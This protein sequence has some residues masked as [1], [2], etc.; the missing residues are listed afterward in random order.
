M[1]ELYSKKDKISLSN[2]MIQMLLIIW[3]DPKDLCHNYSHFVSTARALN[4]R[5]LTIHQHPICP[6]Y[7]LTRKGKR[8]V[9]KILREA[10]S[11]NIQ[12]STQFP[13]FKY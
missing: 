7:L 3:K 1:T 6:P 11:A 5:G 12:E 8:V 9:R 2:R 4:R 13:I 10:N